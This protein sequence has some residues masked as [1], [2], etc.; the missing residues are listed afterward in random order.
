[1]GSRD[2]KQI[3]TDVEVDAAIFQEKSSPFRDSSEN[4]RYKPTNFS[5]HSKMLRSQRGS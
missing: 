2:Q 3:V 1:V 4:L 5:S